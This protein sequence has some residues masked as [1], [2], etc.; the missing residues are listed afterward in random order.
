MLSIS[1]IVSI[2]SFCLY[3]IPGFTFFHPLYFGILLRVSPHENVQRCIIF[4]L[5]IC[6]RQAFSPGSSLPFLGV[7]FLFL[8]K[9]EYLYINVLIPP[10]FLYKPYQ[11]AHHS[12]CY[13]HLIYPANSSISITKVFFSFI[14]TVRK[15]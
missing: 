1:Y 13:F 12:H 4:H 8:Q 5:C 10:S 3:L 9:K 6:D 15:Y 7:C 11:V 14:S 2:T